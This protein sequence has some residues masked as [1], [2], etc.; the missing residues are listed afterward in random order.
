MITIFV[1]IILP[2]LFG[3]SMISLIILSLAIIL[4]KLFK[5]K[6]IILWISLLSLTLVLLI[7]TIHFSDYGEYKYVLNSINKRDSYVIVT[8]SDF[9]QLVKESKLSTSKFGGLYINGKLFCYD[10]STNDN[11]VLAP[12]TYK[13]YLKIKKMRKDLIKVLTSSNNHKLVELKSLKD[14][15]NDNKNS[16]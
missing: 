12:K 16:E 5:F 1:T 8:Y 13:D 2:V 4:E 6:S 3:L 14:A 9:I 11:I 15:F 7:N 10:F